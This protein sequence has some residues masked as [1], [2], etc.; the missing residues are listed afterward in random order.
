MGQK[1]STRIVNPDTWSTRPTQLHMACGK[2]IVLSAGGSVAQRMDAGKQ[3]KNGLVH[4]A[5]PVAVGRLFQV[6]LSFLLSLF[7]GLIVTLPLL[8]TV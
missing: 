6:C 4:T 1:T 5:W 7:S 2:K 8:T 3:H